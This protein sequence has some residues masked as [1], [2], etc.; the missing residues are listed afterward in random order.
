VDELFPNEPGSCGTA[1]SDLDPEFPHFTALPVTNNWAEICDQKKP[2]CQDM[3]YEVRLA[4]GQD[5]TAWQPVDWSGLGSGKWNVEGS[6]KIAPTAGA[7]PPIR[8]P[9]DGF[10]TSFPPTGRPGW[11]AK[12]VFK[13]GPAQPGWLVLDGEVDEPGSVLGFSRRE[14]WGHA[15]LGGAHSGQACHPGQADDCGGKGA[16]TALPSPSYFACLGGVRGGAY[17]TQRQDCPGSQCLPG[18]ACVKI[19][20]SPAPPPPPPTPTPACYTDLDC[21]ADEECGLG[22]FEFR[23]R[24]EGN[25]G[26][27]VIPDNDYKAKATPSL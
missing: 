27:F 1:R 6:T 15:C 24:L 22:L 17:C 2:P 26:P 20:G 23:G 13:K 11:F 21:A 16:C 9:T 19:S 25:A 3:S 4:V 12:P 7:Q 10:L 5:G 8:I 14:E 18:S